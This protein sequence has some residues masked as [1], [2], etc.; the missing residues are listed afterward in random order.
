MIIELAKAILT[1]SFWITLRLA[2]ILV[3]FVV[4]AIALLFRN[5]KPVEDGGRQVY[6]ER[7]VVHLPKWA[8]LWDNDAEGMMSWMPEWPEMCWNGK[9]DS[10]LSMWQ[11]AAWRNPANN[12]RFVR[13]LAVYL[14]EA[15][16]FKYWGNERVADKDYEE[17]QGW[18]F[19]RCKGKYFTYYAF[20]WV[21]KKFYSR[22]GHKFDPRHF[23]PGYIDNAPPRKH[24]K[25]M[26]FRPIQRRRDNSVY[27][28]NQ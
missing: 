1:W 27:E 22:I 21:G 23:E 20:Y 16:S 6:P 14:P 17:G 19:C 24:W 13:G 4:V 10:F 18:Q 28:V 5:E 15:H 2:A 8:W 25:G 7:K 3:G 26:T 9:P 12:M 11:W